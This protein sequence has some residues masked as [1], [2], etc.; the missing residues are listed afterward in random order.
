MSRREIIDCD[1]CGIISSEAEGDRVAMSR[2]YVATLAGDDVLGTPD[3]PADLCS[4]CTASLK[5]WIIEPRITS[6]GRSAA[7]RPGQRRP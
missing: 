5:A 6:G 4:T 2:A 7:Q 3:A 1:R